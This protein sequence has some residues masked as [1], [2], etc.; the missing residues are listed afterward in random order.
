[1]RRLKLPADD[2]SAN[3]ERGWLSDFTKKLRTAVKI[4]RIGHIAFGVHPLPAGKNAVGADV[5][6]T[7]TGN[8]TERRQPVRKKRI[9]SDALDRIVRRCQ[10]LDDTNTVHNDSGPSL[11]NSAD[12]AIEVRSVNAADHIGAAAPSSHRGERFE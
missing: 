4:F 5:D 1:M 9:E 6:Q 3:G 12:H 8:A 7:N 2:G 11:H 10:L